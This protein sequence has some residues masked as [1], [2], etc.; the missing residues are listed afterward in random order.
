MSVEESVISP[1]LVPNHVVSYNI[2]SLGGGDLHEF[3]DLSRDEKHPMY[4]VGL[5]YQWT[6]DLLTYANW[7]NGAKAGGFDFL[8]EGASTEEAEYGDESASVFE[9]GFK[10]DFSDVR[11]NVAAF[12]GNYKDLQVSVYDG[13]IGFLVGNAASSISKGV[14]VDVDWNLSRDLRLLA[15]V[16]YLDFRYDRFTDANCSTTERMNTGAAICDWSGDRT[17][18]VPEFEGVFRAE[19]TAQVFS[20]WALRQSLGYSYRGSHSTASDNEAQTR[21]AAYGLID[22]RIELRPDSGVWS[23]ALRGENLGNEQ[24]NVFTSVIPLSAGGAFASVPAKGRE[25]SVE[26]QYHF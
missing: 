24:Y 6:D 20:N 2:V 9:V 4:H 7:S 14:D 10:R 15:R 21:Q 19:H 5:A 11:L 16:E 22:Y 1:V 23:I 3:D 26:M 13:G 17:P 8:Y 12:Y 25:V 18:F